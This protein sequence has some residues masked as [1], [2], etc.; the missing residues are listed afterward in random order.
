[1]AEIA[2]NALLG[3]SKLNFFVYLLLFFSGGG[4]GHAPRLH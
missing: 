3:L 2:G 1:M 4:G